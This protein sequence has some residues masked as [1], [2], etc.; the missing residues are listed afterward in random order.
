MGHSPLF[1]AEP[2]WC[3]H[4]PSVGCSSWGGAQLNSI[5]PT[6]SPCGSFFASLVPEAPFCRCCLWRCSGESWLCR[7]FRVPGRL[8]RGFLRYCPGPSCYWLAVLIFM[9]LIMRV[10]RVLDIF[11]GI[12]VLS[13]V[14]IY[15]LSL[16]RESS[17]N[18]L[19]NNN[20]VSM[21][22]VYPQH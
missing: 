7:L 1:P 17:V 22:V 13:F 20:C 21:S 8:G 11:I 5:S 19:T 12:Y 6:P 16:N 14:A 9:S 10:N 4:P 18:I 15:I 2:L 3:G